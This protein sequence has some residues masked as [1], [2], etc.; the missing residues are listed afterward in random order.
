MAEVKG[1]EFKETFK[2]ASIIEIENLSLRLISY[3]HLIKAKKSSGRPKDLDDLENL[4][5]RD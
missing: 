4:N 3:D 1:L 2:S 5:E